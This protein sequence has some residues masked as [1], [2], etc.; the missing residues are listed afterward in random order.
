MSTRPC[1]VA[2]ACASWWIALALLIPVDVES[3]VVA[4]PVALGV[5]VAGVPELLFAPAALEPVFATAV[6]LVPTLA[7]WSLVLFDGGPGA[8]A[9]VEGTGCACGPVGGGALWS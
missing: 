6:P 1:S 4:E 7:F 5:P 2:V 8:P 3:P 9:G